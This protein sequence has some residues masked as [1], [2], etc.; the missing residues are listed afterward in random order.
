M[1]GTHS[2]LTSQEFEAL[3]PAASQLLSD[4]PEIIGLFLGL[5]QDRLRYFTASGE[6]VP[7]PE[8]SAAAEMRRAEAEARRR[9]QRR[10][11]RIGWRVICDR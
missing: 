4:E 5:W 11:G 1:Y 2:Y 6:L 3:M 10:I 8:E 7:T 9:R